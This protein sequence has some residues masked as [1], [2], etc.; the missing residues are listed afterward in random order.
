[1]VT[2]YPRQTSYGIFVR[3]RR[4]RLALRRGVTHL[5]EALTI[6]QQLRA[7]RFHDRGEIFV[8]KEPEGTIVELEPAAGAP[9]PLVTA[10]PQALSEPPRAAAPDGV[11][12]HPDPPAPPSLP[13]APA[14][15]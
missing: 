1:M 13:R 3:F 15:D 9:P 5:E 7:S 8:V 10:E 12:I 14:H 2:A 6:A 11:P 4:S